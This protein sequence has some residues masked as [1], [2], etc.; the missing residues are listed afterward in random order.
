MY[1]FFLLQDACSIVFVPVTPTNPH[2][3]IHPQHPN[4]K[5]QHSQHRYILTVPIS[6][7]VLLL[8]FLLHRRKITGGYTA[9]WLTKKGY[10]TSSSDEEA[11]LYEEKRSNS[12]VKHGQKGPKLDAVDL[13][14]PDLTEKQLQ[15]SMC[16]RVVCRYVCICRCVGM[17]VCV[18]CVG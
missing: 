4:P 8:G 16:V 13:Q 14:D 5:P 17:C 3:H 18:G 12:A 9:Y 7:T 6:L 1:K 2:L 10:F 15:V 11:V